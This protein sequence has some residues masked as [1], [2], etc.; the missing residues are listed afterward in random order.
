MTRRPGCPNRVMMTC[1]HS[2]TT[3]IMD[4]TSDAGQA[5]SDAV[6]R[7]LGEERPHRFLEAQKKGLLQRLFG[8]VTG[9]ETRA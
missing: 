9:S 1:S 2:L 8:T 4:D 6:D 5:Y 3:T 7:L